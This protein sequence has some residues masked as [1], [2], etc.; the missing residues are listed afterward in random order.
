[1]VLGD[2]SSLTI[3][4]IAAAAKVTPS[5]IYRRW[6]DLPTLLAEV[7][8]AGLRI[9]PPAVD[10]CSLL[11]D[12][13]VWAKEY[14][15]MMDSGVGRSLVKN[16]FFSGSSF[17]WEQILSHELQV[18]FDRARARGEDVPTID[19]VIDA[20]VAPVMYRV[21]VEGITPQEAKVEKWVYRLL[22]Y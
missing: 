6:G 2:S 10:T 11:G 4:Q 18:I 16:C 3:P 19:Q 5:T 1:M 9:R 12:L 13:L 8:I 22:S 7:G 15:R 21:L 17:V 20:V 14:L